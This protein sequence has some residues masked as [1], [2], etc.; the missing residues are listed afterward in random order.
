VLE[1]AFDTGC[2]VPVPVT[3]SAQASRFQRIAVV[4]LVALVLCFWG[5]LIY[6]RLWEARQPRVQLDNVQVVSIVPYG[7]PGG[8]DVHWHLNGVRVRFAGLPEPV[9][10]PSNSWDAGVTRSE[11]VDAVIRRSF[12]GHEYDGLSVS[13][14]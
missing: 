13:R 1:L 10:Y 6:A 8:G 2:V 4:V 11:H 3:S 7:Q 12:F 5:L 9:D 14:R